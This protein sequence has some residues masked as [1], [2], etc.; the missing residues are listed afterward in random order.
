MRLFVD[1]S[2]MIQIIKLKISTHPHDPT[3]H[4]HLIYVENKVQVWPSGRAL[5]LNASG[6][7]SNSQFRDISS[8]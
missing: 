3:I 8:R 4:L 1:F 2:C 6:P 5:V 7:G